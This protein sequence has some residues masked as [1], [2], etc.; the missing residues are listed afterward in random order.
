M[1]IRNLFFDKIASRHSPSEIPLRTV[2][3]TR[4][5]KINEQ[6]E[7]D[8]GELCRNIRSPGHPT[9]AR[10]E[11]ASNFIGTVSEPMAETTE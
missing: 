7:K 8:R 6:K 5:H 3:A 1:S 2:R 11:T 9:R 4:F 10:S